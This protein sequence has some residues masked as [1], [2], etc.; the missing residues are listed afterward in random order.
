MQRRRNFIVM[1]IVIAVIGVFMLAGERGSGRHLMLDNLEGELTAETV[2]YG[3]DDSSTIN[4]SADTDIKFC[5]KQSLKL[6]Y[7]LQPSGYLFC[8][9]GYGL[10]T[11]AANKWLKDPQK[12]NW[13]RYQG[14][15]FMVSSTQ[16]TIVAFDIKDA[17]DEIWYFESEVVPGDWQEIT[18][19]FDALTVRQDG[20]TQTAA[21]NN[22]L[23]FPIQ[24]YRWESRTPGE[25]TL[26]FDCVKLL[27]KSPTK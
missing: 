4:L 5:G 24:S 27:R 16:K 25:G 21:R 14:F 17:G 22:V 15:S 11:V 10:D 2:D 18:V 20:Q 7:N 9:R 3:A 1:V 26:H 12:I 13:S 8:A 19:S 6:E 23:D